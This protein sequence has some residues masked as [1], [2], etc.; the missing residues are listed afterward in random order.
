MIHYPAPTQLSFFADPGCEPVYG[1]AYAAGLDLRARNDVRIPHGGARPISTG[2]RVEL[3]PGHVGLVRGRSGLAFKRELFAFEGTIDEDYRGEIAVMLAN[4]GQCPQMVR[5][6]ERV[7]QLVVVPCRRVE[8][9]AVDAVEKLAAVVGGRG[10][11][12]FGS[13]GR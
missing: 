10:G 6:G 2:L 13:T 12:G 11:N 9:V 5:A 7:A 8:L 1:N 4:H 3:P